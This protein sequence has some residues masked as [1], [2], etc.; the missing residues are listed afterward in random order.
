MTDELD[1]RRRRA[2][3]RA[4]HRGTKE[5]DV[6][7]GR[8][9]DAHLADLDARGLAQ[10]EQF[11]ALADPLL[12]AWIFGKQSATGSD[13]EKL[14]EDIRIFHGLQASATDAGTR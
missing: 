11:L 8:Y 14:V 1:I 3:Y 10:F 13:F 7:V 5:M 2:A 4:Q 9:A 12:E 6:I